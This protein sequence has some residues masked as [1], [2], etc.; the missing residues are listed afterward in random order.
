MA[1]TLFESVLPNVVYDRR[2][3]QVPEGELLEAEEA[4]DRLEAEERA[5]DERFMMKDPKPIASP[6]AAVDRSVF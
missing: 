2:D 4:L 5:E 6:G 1:L 3:A